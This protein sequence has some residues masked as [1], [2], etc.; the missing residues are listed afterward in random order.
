M[1]TV[2]IENED[3]ALPKDTAEQLHSIENDSLKEIYEYFPMDNDNNTEMDNIGFGERFT[4]EENN[5]IAV[6][7]SCLDL[8]INDLS[9][10]N[11]YDICCRM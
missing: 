2:W 7:E 4:S 5:S 11:D 3:E 6:Q 10:D 1:S 8:D 9:Q